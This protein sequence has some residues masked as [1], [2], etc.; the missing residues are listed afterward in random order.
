MFVDGWFVERS[1]LWPGQAMSLEVEEILYEGKSEF[2]D[3][4]V[5]KSKQHGTVLVLD[6]VIQVRIGGKGGF[7]GVLGCWEE[8]LPLVTRFFVLHSFFRV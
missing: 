5:F 7:G 2:Q 6:G 8:E 1:P 4:I 3:V